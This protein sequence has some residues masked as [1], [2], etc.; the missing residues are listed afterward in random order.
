MYQ[1]D[2]HAGIY[3]VCLRTPLFLSSDW[4][5]TKYILQSRIPF[6]PDSGVARAVEQYQEN[7]RFGKASCSS[8]TSCRGWH[9][10]EEAGYV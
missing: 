9:Y 1:T 3:V 10:S 8:T 7:G 2:T 5:R 6:S 4:R